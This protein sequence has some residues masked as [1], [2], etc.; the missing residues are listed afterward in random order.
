MIFYNQ[1]FDLYHT[2]YR[3]LIILKEFEEQ[4]EIEVDRIRI[5]DFYL[6]FPSKIH[7]I[8]IKKLDSDLKQLRNRFVKNDHNPYE[9]FTHERKIFEKLRPY[10]LAALNCLVSYNILDREKLL[11]NI[12][13]INSKK[14]L[15]DY[16]ADI[17]SISNTEKN[18]I[19]LM[20]KHFYQISL[21]GNDGLKARTNLI[22]SK[23]DI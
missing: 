5:W 2:I 1:A 17:V 9:N 22:E 23:Y 8:N 16:S 6:L 15:K 12:V 14:I 21:F 4:T 11:S 18:I 10:Q 20:T 19:T 3:L 7:N 13:S